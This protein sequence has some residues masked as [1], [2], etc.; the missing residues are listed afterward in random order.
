MRRKRELIRASEMA[1]FSPSHQGMFQM[2]AQRQRQQNSIDAR[3]TCILIRRQTFS[4]MFV[5]RRTELTQ[6]CLSISAAN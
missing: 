2:S 4:G 1:I 3:D 6:S 5:I